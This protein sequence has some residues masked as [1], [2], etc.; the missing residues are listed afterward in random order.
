AEFVKP[1]VVQISVQKK[2][3]RMPNFN[4]RRFQNP[5]PGN[6]RN[7]GGN[8][9]PKDF[10]DMLRKF[11]EVP[12]GNPEKEQFGT[13]SRGVGSGFVFDNRGHIVTNNHVVEDS[14]KITVTFYDGTEAA[15]KVVG[16]DM[17]SDVAV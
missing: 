3:T 9:L 8:A 4:L 7:P 2:A 13:P 1:S 15:A 5:N 16:T 14:D 10:E 17:Q 12:N 11:F 6:P